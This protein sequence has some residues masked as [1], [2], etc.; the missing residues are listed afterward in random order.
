MINVNEG[1]TFELICQIK[2]KGPPSPSV[3]QEDDDKDKDGNVKNKD[4]KYEDY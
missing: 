1:N 3:N 2:G 4:N